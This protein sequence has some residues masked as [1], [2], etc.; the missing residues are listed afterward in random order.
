MKTWFAKVFFGNLS[1]AILPVIDAIGQ[2]AGKE[3]HSNRLQILALTLP[4][5]FLSGFVCTK[6]LDLCRFCTYNN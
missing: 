5:I 4:A 6:S 1:V 2:H 3:C